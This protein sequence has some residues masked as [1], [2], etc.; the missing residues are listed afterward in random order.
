MA[1]DVPPFWRERKTGR[2]SRAGPAVGTAL[3]SSPAKADPAPFCDTAPGSHGSP[4]SR[5]RRTA[6]SCMPGKN[7]FVVLL[8]RR[9]PIQESAPAAKLWRFTGPV[10]RSKKE[11]YSSARCN[12]ARPLSCDHRPAEQIQRIR[13]HHSSIIAIVIIV[14][15]LSSDPTSRR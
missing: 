13:P 8:M 11:K 1:G 9:H 12:V 3:Q 14:F 15:N 5:T 6:R 7:L 10:G 2:G 4:V